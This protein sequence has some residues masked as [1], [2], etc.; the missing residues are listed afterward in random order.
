M[1]LSPSC[2]RALKTT[3]ATSDAATV[4]AARLHCVEQHQ[5]KGKSLILCQ[6]AYLLQL[7]IFTFI[8][9]HSFIC[10]KYLL[11]RPSFLLLFFVFVLFIFSLLHSI[12]FPIRQAHIV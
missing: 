3:F 11:W 9:R 6:A 4:A 1:W 10:L 12:V 2:N 7:Q 5:T 8:H